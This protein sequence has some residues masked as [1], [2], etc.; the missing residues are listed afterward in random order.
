MTISEIGVIIG[1]LVCGYLLV[2]RMLG[3]RNS[4]QVGSR[5]QASAF[6]GGNAAGEEGAGRESD[7]G[8]HSAHRANENG[9][10]QS[11]PGHWSEVLQL[12]ADAS[13]QDIRRAYKALISQYHPDKVADLGPELQ[14]LATRKTQEINVAYRTAL[15]ERCAN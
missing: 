13:T 8:G 1:G 5:G 11:E 14:A 3:D 4:D 7:A 12:P 10:A 2:S 15:N 6:S 9:M